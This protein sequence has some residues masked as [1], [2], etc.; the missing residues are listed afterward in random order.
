MSNGGVES[1]VECT[2]RV[3]ADDLDICSR[4]ARDSAPRAEPIQI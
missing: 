3:M 1:I 4:S 2:D